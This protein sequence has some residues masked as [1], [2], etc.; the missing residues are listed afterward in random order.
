MRVAQALLNFI[1]DARATALSGS[2]DKGRLH[3][4]IPSALSN[5]ILRTS[6]APKEYLIDPVTV[7]LNLTL[8][9]QRERTGPPIPLF[10]KERLK[11]NGRGST[12]VLK[13]FQAR[14]TPVT[15]EDDEFVSLG[16]DERDL[17][18]LASIN[19]I[20]REVAHVLL[21]LVEKPSNGSC[22]VFEFAVP[23]IGSVDFQ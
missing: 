20:F 11:F 1:R 22:F 5:A 12:R 13:K 10:T 8:E 6:V 14:Y 2:S 9:V 16:R 4:V 19:D 3:P 15:I 23:I 7:R 17:I 18:D 21:A